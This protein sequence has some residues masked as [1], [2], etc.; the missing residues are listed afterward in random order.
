MSKHHDH[1]PTI[2]MRP[3]LN[4]ALRAIGI[5]E[6]RRRELSDRVVLDEWVVETI[7]IEIM[8]CIARLN[9]AQKEIDL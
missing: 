2:P 4:A 9:R 3:K 8:H 7:L 6:D 5:P 1:T